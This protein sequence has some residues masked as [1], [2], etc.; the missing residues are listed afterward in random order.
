MFRAAQPA[1]TATIQGIARHSATLS[2]IPRDATGTLAPFWNNPW[3]PPFDGATLYGLIAELR[4]RRFVEVGSGISTRFARQAVVDFGLT[5]RITSIDPH[6][7]NPIDGLCDETIVR[8]ME[9]MPPEFWAGLAQ[10]DMV[11]IDNSHRSFPGSDVTVFFTEVMPGLPPGVVYGIHDIFLP[12]DYPS[13]WNDRFYN[14]QYLLMTYLLGG[15]GGDQIL[16]P[17]YWSGCQPELHGLLAP[18]W[19]QPGLFDGIATH[20]GAFWARRG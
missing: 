8:R 13:A 2:R 10:G 3:F 6:P 5:T 16:L 12:H 4:P 9:D 11:F 15:G 20:G 19:S 7:H 14:E 18:L 17:V 1:I